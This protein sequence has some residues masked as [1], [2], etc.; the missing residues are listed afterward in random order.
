MGADIYYETQNKAYGISSLIIALRLTVLFR[1]AQ[2]AAW[3][4]ILTK[5]YSSE[6]TDA[7]RSLFPEPDFDDLYGFGPLHKAVLSIGNRSLQD[8]LRS[9]KLDIDEPDRQGRTALAWA[10]SRNDTKGVQILLS[11]G[12]NM[13]TA[14][15]AGRIPIHEAVQ[16]GLACTR[17]LIGAGADVTAKS[18]RGANA[19]HY[20]SYSDSDFT[21]SEEEIVEIAQLLLDAGAKIN[22]KC[23]FGR[24]SLIAACYANRP[25][26]V[27]LFIERGADLTSHDKTGENALSFAIRGNCHTILQQLLSEHLDHTGLLTVAAEAADTQTLKI[28]VAQ[29]DHFKRR[30][31]NAVDRAKLTAWQVA[32]QRTDVDAEWHD[33]FFG[34]MRAVDEKNVNPTLYDI[35][36]PA[37][38]LDQ[39]L[40]DSFEVE[41]DEADQDFVEALE[42]QP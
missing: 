24:T 42:F 32:S 14:C 15:W 40:G 10:A 21:M 8:I 5:R 28:L 38:Q 6:W 12:A 33:A 11:Y 30:N 39:D 1:S 18:P 16:S 27:K 29:S 19:L 36:D 9:G 23:S 26:L 37:A 2:M 35:D 25:K 3:E 4:K 31:M 17:L 22:A 7:M 20:I 34:F 13:E 41:D